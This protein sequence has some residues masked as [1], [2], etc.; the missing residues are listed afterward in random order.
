MLGK[1]QCHNIHTEQLREFSKKRV[2]LV[3]KVPTTSTIATHN[4]ALNYVFRKAFSLKYIQYM[5]RLISNDGDSTKKRRSYFNDTE[6]RQLNNG[7]GQWVKKTA[8]LHKV[9]GGRNGIDTLSDTSFD[10]RMMVRDI[11]LMLVN[12]GIRVGEEL[13]NLKW[14]NLDIFEQD[15]MQSI[16]FSLTYTK[17]GMQRVV[18]GYEP[19]RKNE[20]ERYGC[21]MPLQGIAERFPKLD[22]M[23]W[24][25]LFQVDEPTDRYHIKEAIA[26]GWLVP[27]FI[28]RAKTF[29]IIKEE[30]FEVERTDI[31][32]DALPQD[33]RD[34]LEELFGD[35]R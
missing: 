5:P 34:E 31:D 27:F 15:G 30:G 26:D 25:T 4:T 19:I 20:D 28:Y 14:N 16:H 1:I 2:E 21:W 33:E 11:V 32:W 7:M 35:V 9:K 23:N 22:K 13:L 10:I 18:I 24:D 8:E 29:S 6:M 3:G 17:T 12:T